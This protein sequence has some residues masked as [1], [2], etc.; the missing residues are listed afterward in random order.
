[1]KEDTVSKYMAAINEGCSAKVVKVKNE[2]LKI[3]GPGKI[4][5]I[6]EVH[7]AE[8]KYMRGTEL[9]SEHFWVFGMIEV[10]GGWIEFEDEELY[11]RLIK[12]EKPRFST[13][14]KKCLTK[15]RRRNAPRRR[16]PRG[17]PRR[18]P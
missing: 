4:V 15:Q 13:M 9:V 6:D 10:E 8:R 16:S 14:P 11:K 17:M 12:S 5:E 18:C 1:M 3:G 7:L 2:G